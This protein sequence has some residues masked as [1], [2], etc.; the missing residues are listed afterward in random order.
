[1]A[2]EEK[3]LAT[4]NASA[5]WIAFEDQVRKLYAPDASETEWEVFKTE[6]RSLGLDPTKREFIALAIGNEKLVDD[7]GRPVIRNGKPVWRKKYAG[8][9]T[10][11]GARA[12]AARTGL[13]DGVDGPYWCGPDGN[14]R[15]VW[16]SDGI[17][18]A[19]KFTVYVKGMSRGF[20][21]VCTMKQA[22]TKINE[23]TNEKELV[24]TWATMPDVMLAV[25]AELSALRRAGLLSDVRLEDHFVA[26]PV[27]GELLATPEELNARLT[28]GRRIHA[29]G[30]GRG[31][32]HD[33]VSNVV[34]TVADVDSMSDA[35][36][37]DLATAAD[38]IDVLDSD[39]L[40]SVADVEPETVDG[41]RFDPTPESSAVS[42]LITIEQAQFIDLNWK[43]LP[44]KKLTAR[45]KRIVLGEVDGS[46]IT[47]A[48]ADA[49]VAK[50]TKQQESDRAAVQSGKDTLAKA[51]SGA[52]ETRTEDERWTDYWKRVRAAGLNRDSLVA[53]SGAS[54]VPATLEDAE[55][56]LQRAIASKPT[57]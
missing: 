7:S 5:P 16:L 57:E 43:Y 29:I 11:H 48:E 46:E 15:E 22:R 8:Y 56:V 47:Y 39:G 45:E 2:A 42:D 4:I 36:S 32:G 1:M 55:I 35:V 25:R 3:Q 33:A 17:P 24:G 52:T 54:G 30:A 10:I 21:G 9:V 34:R 14:W 26:D 19:A 20:T 38:V 13:M 51:K 50:I 6:A 49:L 40:A 28:S 18:A 31:L 23:N 12:L 41:E 27:S 44:E 53:F 37:T